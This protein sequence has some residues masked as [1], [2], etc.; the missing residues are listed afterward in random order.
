MKK[1]L[2]IVMVCVCSANVSIAQSQNENQSDRF[3]PRFHMLDSAS[4]SNM[5]KARHNSWGKSKKENEKKW[6]KHVAM[7][8]HPHMG[9]GRMP[10]HFPQH[11][12]QFQKEEQLPEFVGGEEALMD[13]IEDNI[14]YPIMASSNST[15]GKVVVTFDVNDDGTIG[16]VKVKE[17]ANPILDNE[18]V[19]KIENMPNWIPAKQNGR[20]VKVKY[21][22]PVNFVALS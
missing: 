8:Q 14:T 10:Q 17:S 22:L 18:V 11:F 7:W 13:W 1:L 5:M 15:E 9:F 3:Q 12:F 4:R 19:S 16:N 6:K 20:T 2:A 21:T